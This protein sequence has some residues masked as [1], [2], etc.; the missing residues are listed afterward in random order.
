MLAASILIALIAIPV[1]E[2]GHVIGYRITGVA[3]RI[4]YEHTILPAGARLSLSG[5]TCGVLST[6]IASYI[7]ILLIYRKRW[8][9]VAYPLA[10]ILNLV[11]VLAYI[12]Y[13]IRFHTLAGL[14]ESQMATFT[15]LNPYFWYVPSGA[16]FVV[17]WILI[18]RSLRHGV[19]RNVVLCAF[20]VILYIVI[21]T[22][23]LYVVGKYFPQTA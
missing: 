15:G 22:F 20:P 13:S 12:N 6:Y 19:L 9:L 10:V 23:C 21:S 7:G 3:A 4:A 11:R 2:L 18:I 5:T 8:L 16:L 17:A 1:H 14:D